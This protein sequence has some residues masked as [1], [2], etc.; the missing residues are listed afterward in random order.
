MAQ[1]GWLAKRDQCATMALCISA[2][3]QV[4]LVPAPDSGMTL[5]LGDIVTPNPARLNTV[6][7]SMTS[8]GRL[9][10]RLG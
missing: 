7:R 8:A 2:S 6:A 3:L 9:A 1:S 10:G 5:A 4:P